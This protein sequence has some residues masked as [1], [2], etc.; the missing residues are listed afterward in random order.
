MTNT[1]INT[2]IARKMGEDACHHTPRCSETAVRNYAEQIEDSWQIINWIGEKCSSLNLC[3]DEEAGFWEFTW[4]SSGQRYTGYGQTAPTA[5]CRG[6]LNAPVGDSL[7]TP[8]T[9]KG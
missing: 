6:F 1:E 9:E 4:V 7:A 3:W 2:V 8:P 5:I